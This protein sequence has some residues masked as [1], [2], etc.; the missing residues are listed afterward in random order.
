M[1][2]LSVDW[3]ETWDP[4]VSRFYHALGG[5][6]W[7]PEELL[8][9][10]CA[11]QSAHLKRIALVTREGAPWA[12]VP[13]RWNTRSWRP[14]L[15][16]ISDP[17]PLT[18]SQGG[19]AE[20]MAALNIGVHIGFGRGNPA[21]IRNLR[22][23][24]S[25]PCYELDLTTS[26]EVYWRTTGRWK[27]VA[28]A[29]RRGSDFTLLRNDAAF[30]DWTI[31]AWRERWSTGRASDTVA[32]WRDRLTF[33]C[34]G[35]ESGAVRSWILLDQERPVA[36]AIAVVG[37]GVMNIQTIIRDQEYDWYGVG[38]RIVAEAMMDAFEFGMERVAFGA[39]FA[40][41][42]WWAP[43]TGLAYSYILAPFPVHVANWAVDRL[44]RLGGQLR[45]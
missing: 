21:G 25:Q 18:L 36:G 10:L 28:Q 41:K 23:T 16:G 7:L 35:L 2:G 6:D 39:G 1:V 4:G 43:P 44:D 13:M 22:W 30:L 31:R 33:N 19:L 17:F 11:D 24:S 15:H 8:I 32:Q 20:T 38:N 29:R 26:P 34:W 14:L 27:T 9:R 45:R 5:G 3:H 42:R 40:Y 37:D 12:L